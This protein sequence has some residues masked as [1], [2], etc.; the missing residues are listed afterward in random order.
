MAR[1]YGL[2][3]LQVG[4]AV[5]RRFEAVPTPGLNRVLG[6]GI[7]EPATQE[8]V[9][10][11]IAFYTGASPIEATALSVRRGGRG[12]APVGSPPLDGVV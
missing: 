6:L 8:M 7:Q 9:D 1:E 2:V 5:A 12:A 3:W 4:G 11:L 10:E